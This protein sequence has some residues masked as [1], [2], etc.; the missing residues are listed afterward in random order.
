MDTF[1]EIQAYFTESI[2]V[3]R[4]VAKHMVRDID[5]VA[6]VVAAALKSGKKI[7]FFGNGGSAADSQHLAAEFIGRFRVERGP[8]AA[9]A[10]TTDTSILTA[11]GND[12][13]YDQVFVRQIVGLGVPG[14]IAIGI[15]TSGNSMNVIKGL[16]AAKKLGLITVGM[17]GGD[18]GKM[19]PIVE[20]HINVAATRA[21]SHVQESHITIGHIIMELVDQA[22]G[23]A[24][25]KVSKELNV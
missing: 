18:G 15:S 11:I 2:R 17:T 14:D 5:G 9:V 3:K 1:Q 20:H 24:K 23:L 25:P 8:L 6:R 4:E 13:G 12:F 19:G 7:L 21:T 10:L 22:L 16:E